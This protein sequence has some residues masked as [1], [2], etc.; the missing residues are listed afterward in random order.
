M[1]HE[2]LLKERENILALCAEK[3]LRVSGSRTSSL[4]MDLGLP[5]FYDEL[6]E[7]L[8]ADEEKLIAGADLVSSSIHSDS[9]IRRGK[10]SL[11]LGY[12]VSQVVFSYGALCQS[13]TEYAGKCLDQ[14]IEPREFNRLNI[15]LD[16][17]IAEA[18]TEFTRGQQVITSEEEVGRL[19]VLA[20]EM[21]NTLARAIAAHR[22]IKRGVVGFAGSTNKVLEDSLTQLKD[23]IDRSLSEVRLRIE[24]NVDRVR[25]RVID[26]VGEVEA[27]AMSETSDKSLGLHIQVPPDLEVSVD[28]HLLVSAIS[29]LVQ[30]AIKF[31]K[32]NGNVCIRGT[33]A[34]DRV[35]IEV[36][37][38]CGGL[39]PGKIEE[40][41]QPY[42]QKHSDKTG[43]GLGLSIARR[44]I[45]R[46][47]GQL[48]AHDI[49]GKGCVFTI[50][51]E[52]FVALQE[53]TELP[54]LSLH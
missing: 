11:K 53:E 8:R 30:N 10:E 29:N 35:L 6:I 41:F 48:S 27:T 36:E 3:L 9:A 34:G 16:I 32:Q 5:I 14:S 19:G 52:R 46:N 4:E 23:I 25:C 12:T 43:V 44:A 15:C 54:I 24:P 37:D 51:L 40:L 2:F 45:A 7:I 18:V 26:L 49:P 47:G 22:M 31:T 1:L 17:A 50:T 28:R 21:R 42:S 13:I 20:H 39:P 33:A 38:E